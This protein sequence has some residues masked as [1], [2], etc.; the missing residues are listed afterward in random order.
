MCTEFAMVDDNLWL[1]FDDTIVHFAKVLSLE[2]H[3]RTENVYEEKH[4]TYF[5]LIL[6][7]TAKIWLSQVCQKSENQFRKSSQ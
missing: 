6:Y 2:G 3:E 1:K 7:D 5:K 4:I